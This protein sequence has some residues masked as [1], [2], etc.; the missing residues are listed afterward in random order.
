MFTAVEH[1][2]RKYYTCVCVCD[3]ERIN[4]IFDPR[5][6]EF[7]TMYATREV[8]FESFVR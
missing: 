6:N 3:R 7:V 5:E 1:A 8:N 2:A 4:V